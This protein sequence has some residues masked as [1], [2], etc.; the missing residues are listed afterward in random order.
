MSSWTPE[1]KARLENLYTSSQAEVKQI[2]T[3]T[4]PVCLVMHPSSWML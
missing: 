1:K 4:Q 3:F 2:F